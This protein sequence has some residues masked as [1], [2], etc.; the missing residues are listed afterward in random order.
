MAESDVEKFR[1]AAEGA[2]AP[3]RE[4]LAELEKAFSWEAVQANGFPALAFKDFLSKVASFRTAGMDLLGS[5]GTPRQ[6][7]DVFDEI[8]PRGVEEVVMDEKAHNELS[9]PGNNDPRSYR[10]PGWGISG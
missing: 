8:M 2:I 10:L 4:T 5:T 9:N 1:E 6:I 3:I 7:L